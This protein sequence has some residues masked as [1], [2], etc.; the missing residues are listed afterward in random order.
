MAPLHR[1][2]SPGMFLCSSR[3]QR[4]LFP[5]LSFAL[6]DVSCHGGC[7]D[8]VLHGGGLL[9][10]GG[11]AVSSA[12]LAALGL[13]V[14]ALLAVV[15]CLASGFLF[16]SVFRGLALCRSTLTQFAEQR[17]CALCFSF[18]FCR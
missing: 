18:L 12:M 2:S 3:F 4:P 7:H 5:V 8:A 11:L 10:S 9:L 14:A 16:C 1:A 13:L 15:A 6:A 17:F